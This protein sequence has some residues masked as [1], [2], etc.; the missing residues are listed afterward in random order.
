MGQ[1]DIG[2]GVEVELFV[3]P[4][5]GAAQGDD[6]VHQV[7]RRS[8]AGLFGQAHGVGLADHRGRGGLGHHQHAGDGRTAGHGGKA[9]TQDQP[10]RT[11]E[12]KTLQHHQTPTGRAAVLAAPVNFI[13]QCYTGRE[14][15]TA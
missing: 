14:L 2:A 5:G 8:K 6:V 4:G 7:H 9:H 11:T 1:V 3:Q 12:A 15:R 10:S 13:W